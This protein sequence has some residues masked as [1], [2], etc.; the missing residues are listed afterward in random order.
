VGLPAPLDQQRRGV[1]PQ[2]TC[3]A[4][5]ERVAPPAQGLGRRQAVGGLA[6]DELRE[7]IFGEQLAVGSPRLGESSSAAG[8]EPSVLDP[9]MG[10]DLA[11]AVADDAPKKR[12]RAPDQRCSA[13]VRTPFVATPLPVLRGGAAVGARLSAVLGPTPAVVRGRLAARAA[14]L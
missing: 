11:A 13:G 3:A 7:A 8:I 9:A 1:V 2:G 12:V 5:D 14:P 6:L 4:L 10:Y